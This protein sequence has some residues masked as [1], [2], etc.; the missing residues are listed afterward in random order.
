MSYK[1]NFDLSN[2]SQSFFR[3]IVKMSY[4]SKIHKK[5]GEKARYLVEKFKVDKFTGL[6][7]EN[8]IS[9]VEDFI[10]TSI[11]NVMERE[12]FLKTK[13]RVLLLPHCSRKFMDG[14]C[15]AKFNSKIPSY[16]CNHCSPDCLVS[17]ATNL[18]KER[19]HDVF[20]ISGG[21]CITKILEK[22]HYDGVIGV[23]CCEE[24]IVTKKYLNNMNLKSQA[25]PLIKNGCANTRFNIKD[26]EAVV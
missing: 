19:G 17:K 11:T 12:D 16:F 26:L 9:I 7:F 25:L 2:F 1:F 10:D 14:R 24:I 21:S 5:V 3:E 4:R 15:K 20:I 23:A 22:S 6:P 13:K 8:A 18:A